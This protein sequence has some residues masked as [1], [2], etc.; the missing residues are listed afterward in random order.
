MRIKIILSY[1]VFEKQRWTLE[2]SRCSMKLLMF[3]CLN[4]DLRSKKK[5]T[6]YSSRGLN[7][8][9]IRASIL[10]AL[11]RTFLHLEKKSANRFNVMN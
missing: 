10:I 7:T 5:I 3:G 11:T 1:P 6:S 2:Y 8:V 9:K 4:V